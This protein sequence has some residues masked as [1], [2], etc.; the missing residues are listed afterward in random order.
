MRASCNEQPTRSRRTCLG[1]GSYIFCLGE[2]IR[3]IESGNDSP[4]FVGKRGGP[5]SKQKV[6]ENWSRLE[7]AG[8]VR[9][10][11]EPKVNPSDAVIARCE[12]PPLAVSGPPKPFHTS[13]Q[14]REALRQAEPIKRKKRAGTADEKRGLI[15]GW[16]SVAALLEFRRPTKSLR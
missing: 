15:H 6:I 5:I 10:V 7:S 3:R 12:G 2:G 16:S 4:R 8:S 9:V 14:Q 11:E 13:I 1:R